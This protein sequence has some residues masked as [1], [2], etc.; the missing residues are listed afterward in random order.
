MDAQETSEN[1]DTLKLKRRKRGQWLLVIAVILLPI[2]YMTYAI[3]GN[4]QMTVLLLGLAGA[5]TGLAMI[6]CLILG[7]IFLIRGFAGK[8]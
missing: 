1:K 2:N 4:D 5:I 8:K 6:V 3:E 7:I